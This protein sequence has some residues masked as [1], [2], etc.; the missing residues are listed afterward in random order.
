MSDTTDLPLD[1]VRIIDLSSIVSGPMATSILADQGAEV[2][3]IEQPGVG[4][5]TRYMGPSR[6]GLASIF[7]TV[8]RNK[9]SIALNLRSA[10]GKALLHRLVETADVVVQNFRPGVADRMG[11][12]HEELRRLRPELIYVS[13][14]GFGDTGPYVKQRVYDVVIQALTGLAGSQL[15]ANGDPQLIR[16]IVCDK[17]TAIASAQVISA[18]LFGRERTGKGRHVEL[19]MLDVSVA[20]VWPD[21]MSKHTYVGEDYSNTPSIA[22]A[23]TPY[24][25]TDGH[26]ALLTVSQEE[27]F[28]LARAIGQP[29][30]IEDPRFSTLEMQYKN[31]DTLHQII[32]DAAAT[33]STAEFLTRLRA[34]D[35]PV[36][37]IVRPADVHE[38]EQIRHNGIIEETDHPT[39]GRIRTPN[40]Y[41]IFDNVRA[42]IRTPAPL[43]GEHTNE[44]LAE[45]GESD[46][47]I[48]SLRERE[49]VG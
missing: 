8:N 5:L 2:I 37:P 13:I 48:A 42:S 49:I 23:L 7:T 10:D 31:F 29:E 41:V 47:A 43:L 11:I 1:G 17:A 34:E 24:P 39:A 21:I 16:N 46:D 15:D 40:S 20:F 27:F 35:V 30:L 4:D 14:S 6:G 12:G 32:L 33:M 19:S 9:R 28:G 3:K 44:I 45:L 38:D 25:T 36:A 26:A 18:A 22:D